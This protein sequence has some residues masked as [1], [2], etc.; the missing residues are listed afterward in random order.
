VENTALPPLNNPEALTPVKTKPSRWLAA[1]LRSSRPALLFTLVVNLLSAGI[2]IAQA[3][4]T[5]LIIANVFLEGSTLPDE[6]HRLV[7]LLGCLLLRAGFTF[8][9]EVSAQAIARR[10]KSS[11][12]L[13]LFD[14]LF[15]LGPSV[16]QNEKTAGLT[17]AALAGGKALKAGTASSC[18]S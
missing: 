2:V 7:L 12:R 4:L 5:S 13:E 6:N 9:G 10:I 3:F 11:I 16:I 14:H 18:R 15:K 8:A 1:H 17:T